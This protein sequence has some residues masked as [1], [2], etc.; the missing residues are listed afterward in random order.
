G[1]KLLFEGIN[2]KVE[3]GERIALIGDNGTGKSTLVSMITEETY[4][5]D[6]R[7]KLGPAVKYACLPQIIHFDHPDWNLVE[8][9]MAARRDLSA[10]SARNRLAA[11]EFRGEDV[12]KPVSVLSGGEQSRLRLCMLM[13]DEI[14]FLILD[15]PTNHLDIDSREWMEDAVE[16]YDGTL[17]FVSHDRYFINR[18]ATRIWELADGTITDY[19]M[20]FTQYRQMKAQEELQKYDAPKPVKEKTVT[21]RSRSNRGQQAAR[22]QLTIVERD[23]A[24]TE[25]RLSALDGAME[26]AACDYEK[27]GELLQ[28]K[29]L[30]Q[31]ELEALYEK[32]EALSEEGE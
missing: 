7:I 29:E 19:P 28:E 16:A 25:E 26:A 15:E 12:F 32:W 6:G 14:N 11:Y 21:E 22:R 10:Q 13:D 24:K 17:L 23:V 5:D 9:M 18:F 27:L 2:L 8:N 20:G 30:V 3:G 31:A 4:P 1:D